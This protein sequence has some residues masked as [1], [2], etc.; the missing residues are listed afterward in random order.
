MT[1]RGADF[2]AYQ[3]D[4]HLETALA[5]GIR[6]A[7][8]KLTEGTGYVNAE[9]GWQ[10]EQLRAHGVACGVYHYLDP[11]NGGAQWVHFRA[12]LEQLPDHH[13]L[14]VALDYEAA[15]ATDTG[16]QTFI[17]AGRRAGWL[18]GC[19]SSAGTHAYARLG[20]AWRWIAAWG[21]GKPPRGAAFWQFRAG[22]D[23]SP[24]WDLFLGSQA[25]LERFWARY[26][27]QGLYRLDVPAQGRG[28]PYT[29]WYRS[30]KAAAAAGVWFA[31]RHPLRRR[32]VVTRLLP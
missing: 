14:L 4:A 26:A 15:G 22:A 2:S 5:Q 3:D 18:V 21:T 24:D 30:A 1:V 29:A 31:L 9:A 20:Q 19:Y 17:Y 28:G 27:G 12:Q 10:L 13:R 6:F 32:F 25:Q 23:G 7:F 16:A 11:S 8:V